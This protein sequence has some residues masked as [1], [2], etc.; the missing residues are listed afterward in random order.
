MLTAMLERHVATGAMSRTPAASGEMFTAST[1]LGR[2]RD[3][4]FSLH[5]T[6]IRYRSGTRSIRTEVWAKDRR[7]PKPP[8]EANWPVVKALRELAAGDMGDEVIV[9]LLSAAL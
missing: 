7:V 6:I 2:F 8:M 9:R 5:I 4:T 3:D 1:E